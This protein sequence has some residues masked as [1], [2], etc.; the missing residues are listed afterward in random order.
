MKTLE[1]HIRT[2]TGYFARI[3]SISVSY[4]NKSVQVNYKLCSNSIVTELP[5]EVRNWFT[6][7][8]WSPD[9]KAA[10]SDSVPT[11][12][13]AHAVLSAFGGIT[14]LE[15]ECP[16]D[17]EPIQEFT[18]RLLSTTGGH[19]NKWASRLKSTLIGIADEHNCHAKLYIDEKGRCFSDSLVHDCFAF[20]GE[21]LAD[22]LSGY[23]TNRRYR[24]LLAPLQQQVSIYGEWVQRGDPRIWNYKLNR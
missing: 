7:C 2:K 9:H 19:I 3:C 10:V 21:S 20:A 14:L 22:T 4:Q 11:A 15:R 6:E 18:F 5:T 23:L 16:D 24:A 1:H 8:G 17:D 13:P 12:H